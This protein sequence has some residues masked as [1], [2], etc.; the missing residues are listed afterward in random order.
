MLNDEIKSTLRRVEL[1]LR[2]RAITA[3]ACE[4]DE[5]PALADDLRALEALRCQLDRLN[6]ERD[7]P[8]D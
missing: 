1:E 8:N 6:R 7:E 3:R 5:Y 4:G 2:I